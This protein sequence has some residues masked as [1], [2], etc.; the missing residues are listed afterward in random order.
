MGT[1]RDGSAVVRGGHERA[2]KLSAERRREIAVQGAAARWRDVP[3]KATHSGVLH[4]ADMELDCANLPDGRRVISE[5]AMMRAL[6]RGYS[7]NPAREQQA[8]EV[9]AVKCPDIWLPRPSR[10]LFPT[11]CSCCYGAYR[12]W[13]CGAAAP[14]GACLPRPCRRSVVSGCWPGRQGSSTP[15]RSARRRRQR[16]SRSDSPRSASSRSS[17]R[18]PAIR[19]SARGTSYRKYLRPTSRASC[20]PGRS[21]SPMSSSARSTAC[22]GGTSSR[23]ASAGRAM[24]AS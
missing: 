4:I 24:W 2:R 14:R 10:R 21:G 23:E 13:T 8:P 18:P 5:R 16:S 22:T 3:V 12:I 20:C 19:R 1:E 17:T 15:H 6:G 9:G 7:G 11:T